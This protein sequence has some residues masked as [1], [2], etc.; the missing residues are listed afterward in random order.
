MGGLRALGAV[1]VALIAGVSPL[2]FCSQ[3]RLAA[4][5]TEIPEPRGVFGPLKYHTDQP[6]DEDE[7]DDEESE[8]EPEPEEI[9]NPRK[10]LVDRPHHDLSQGS[11][12]KRK[13]LSNGYDN[14]AAA[15]SATTP[16][17]VDH[18]AES[19]GHAYPSPLE[20]EQPESPLARTE[21][22]SRGTQVEKVRDLTH[23]T[24]FLRLSS[25]ES[26]EPSD[27][28][29]VLLSEW[30]PRDPSVLAT[31]GTDALARIWTLPKTSISG[32]APD[33]ISDEIANNHVTTPTLTSAAS[34][35]I[36]EEDLPKNATISAMAW[37][38]SGEFLATGA[39]LGSKSR[40]SIWTA[41]GTRVQGFD[42][43]D[44]PITNLCW[45][46]NNNYLLAISPDVSNGPENTGTLIHVSSPSTPNSM[47]HVL[48]HDLRADSLD[49]AWISETE[50]ILCGGNLLVSF[51]CTE[52]GIVPM[53]EFATGKDERFSLVQFDCR[54]KLVATASDKGTVDVS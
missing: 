1:L 44:S 17:D 53:K 26:T 37:S 2:T 7:E 4:P 49:A 46:P 27:N 48:E 34:I 50:F 30:N 32:S 10:R 21:G 14:G 47:S 11:P 18:P 45:S 13:R 41:S 38:A 52:Q 39:E 22:P 43:L 5:G 19:N 51:R 8:P 24:V 35:N 42:G 25:D 29:I 9:E 54:S 12:A 3:A 36:V 31:A 6:V 28:P 40:V 33:T 15:D 23:G 20:G 16:M